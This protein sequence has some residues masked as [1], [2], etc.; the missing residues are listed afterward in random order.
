MPETLIYY[1]DKT[2]GLGTRAVEVST[3][4]GARSVPTV[5]KQVLVSDQDR[6]VIAFGCDAINSSSLR[7][8]ATVYKTRCLLDFHLKKMPWIGSQRTQTLLA[9]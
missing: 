9:I 1:W 4:V 6:H 2:G 7:L 5:A 8:K 3:R